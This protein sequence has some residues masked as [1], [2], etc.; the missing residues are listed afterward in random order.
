LGAGK[1]RIATDA[2]VINLP[3]GDADARLDKWMRD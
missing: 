3:D 1:E 2:A